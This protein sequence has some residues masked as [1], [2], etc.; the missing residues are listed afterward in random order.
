MAKFNDEII[1]TEEAPMT[2]EEIQNEVAINEAELLRSLTRKDHNEDTTKIEVKFRGVV[3]RFRIRALSE[4]EYDDCRE[5]CTKYSK[6]R[7]LGNMRLPEKTDTVRYHTLLIYTATVEEDRAKLWDNK[8][9]WDAVNAV[10]GTDM[11]DRLI[12]TAGKKQSIVEQI[13]KLSGFDD[14]DEAAFEET[15][16]N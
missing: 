12:P 16:K 3:F 4:R 6:N 2:T 7:R 15:V 1:N 10:T 5:K 13:E 11:V 8:T 14:E 9:L